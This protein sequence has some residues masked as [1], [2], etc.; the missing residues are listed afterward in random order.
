MDNAS[1]MNQT[2]MC[3]V[4]S[5]RITMVAVSII[6]II[7]IILLVMLPVFAFI[8][9]ITCA[10]MVI[11]LG[12]VCLCKIGLTPSMHSDIELNMDINFIENGNQSDHENDAPVEHTHEN[13]IVSCRD[14]GLQYGQYREMDS[15]HKQEMELI[16]N[17]EETY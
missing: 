11:P 8:I 1:H 17:I 9:I 15:L 5:I 12:L 7:G 4:Y 3:L 13:V 14:T 6:C 2:S 16:K 10:V